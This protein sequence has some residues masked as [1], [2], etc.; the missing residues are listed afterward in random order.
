M[1]FLPL[2]CEQYMKILS[3][4]KALYRFYISNTCCAFLVYQMDWFLNNMRGASHKVSAKRMLPRGG[5]LNSLGCL[6]QGGLQ[7]RG[8]T[9]KGLLAHAEAP[10]TCPKLPLDPSLNGEK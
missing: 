2:D 7:W 4:Y 10:L 1:Y 9:S 5:E 6:L 3:A 8:R